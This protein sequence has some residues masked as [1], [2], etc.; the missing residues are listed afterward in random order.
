MLDLCPVNVSFSLLPSRQYLPMSPQSLATISLLT[1]A[2]VCV[3]SAAGLCAKYVSSSMPG[4]V[5]YK[6]FLA[7]VLAKP[8][9]SVRNTPFE[10]QSTLCWSSVVHRWISKTLGVPGC[11]WSACAAGV[12][13][14]GNGR[15][16]GG[17]PHPVRTTATSR[18]AGLAWLACLFL[19][20]SCR[21][22]LFLATCGSF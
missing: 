5:N 18:H 11:V 15:A 10:P 2:P 17:A 7:D 8:R 13:A 6:P 12:D 3:C 9:N 1:R 14:E 16:R 20:A 19:V 21:L 4:F 22:G